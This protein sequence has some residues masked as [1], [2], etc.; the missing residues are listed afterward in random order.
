MTGKREP[1][2]GQAPDG[3]MTCK[4][5]TYRTPREIYEAQML[6]SGTQQRL[7]ECP[8]CG[9]MHLEYRRET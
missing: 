5:K 1:E 6:T 8:R 2:Q 3:D 9:G 4:R 7:V